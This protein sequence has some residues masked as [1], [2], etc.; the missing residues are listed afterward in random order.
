MHGSLAAPTA[1]FQP[2]GQPEQQG[3][4]LGQPWALLGQPRAQGLLAIG[5][6]GLQ[7]DA[8]AKF[9]TFQPAPSEEGPGVEPSNLGN[10]ALQP[11][12]ST[13]WE[14]GAEA[15]LFNDRWSLDVTYWNRTVSDALVARQFSVTGGFVNQQL[16]NIGELSGQGVGRGDGGASGDE[17]GR[18]QGLRHMRDPL[19]KT[20]EP[21]DARPP[22]QWHV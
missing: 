14:V 21:E 12:V 6:S 7:P 9:T 13:E 2:G 10:D 17:Q 11:E 4:E 8:F 20:G 16:V 15:G 3:S 5:R 19:V 18:F 22:T 1:L